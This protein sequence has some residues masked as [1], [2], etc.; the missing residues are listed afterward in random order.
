[1]N[2]SKI[3]HST[4]PFTIILALIFICTA[5]GLAKN[6]ADKFLIVHLDGISSE[7]FYE[8]LE[9]GHLPNTANLFADG[10]ALKY[11]V[12]VFPGKTPLI[13]SRLKTGFDN[14][15]GIV[16]WAYIDPD[17]GRKVN[18]VEVFFQMLSHVDRRSHSLF[19]F[20]YPGLTELAGL[21]LLNL[22]RLWETHD[23][24]EFYWIYADSQGHSNGKD[25]YIKGLHKFDSYLGLA[26]E[27]GQLEGSNVIFYADHGLTV[28]N[29][30]VIRDKRLIKKM[31][32]DEMRYMFYPNIFLTN[33]ERKEEY[34]QRIVSE[35][36]VDLG[37]IRNSESTILGFFDQ[38]S[39]KVTT[40]GGKY[41]YKY[42]GYDYFGYADLG[43]NQ[44]YLTKDEWLKLTRAHKYP[45]S[46]P[47]LFDYLNHKD[48]G[49]IVIVLN[50][51]KI[52]WY[53]PNVKAHHA[54]LTSNDMRI[55]ILF[56][57]P[58]FEDVHPPE[59]MWIYDLFSKYLTMVDFDAPKHQE[60]HFVSLQYPLE[61]EVSFSP[62]YRVRTGL[63]VNEEQLTPWLE[64]DLYSSFLTRFW[65]GGRYH[66]QQLDW[67]LNAEGFIGDVKVSWLKHQNDPGIFSLNYRINDHMELSV[68]TKKQLGISVLF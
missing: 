45:A 48:V 9:E 16:G 44:E 62:A 23:I 66:N 34:A 63:I 33:P 18:Q 29:V 41:Q 3:T 25:S 40:K 68:N 26:M 60:R 7:Y 12:T 53:K 14:S 46:P 36:P 20:K 37:V 47:I 50:A 49:D 27:S 15:E 65:V 5:P 32:G 21:S 61:A 4:T 1:M 64:L 6:R 2:R 8:E 19:A 59:E 58:A 31:L 17:T 56:T 13:V 67:R 57:G 30:E 24:L 11:G 52:S 43:Y 38:G 22:D 28:E 35:T 54:G 55:P 39:F 10:H 51:P 42:E